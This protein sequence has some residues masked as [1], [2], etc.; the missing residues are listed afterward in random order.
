MRVRGAADWGRAASCRVLLEEETNR[1]KTE[2]NRAVLVLGRYQSRCSRNVTDALSLV[3]LWPSNG[4]SV[5]HRL[6]VM[7]TIRDIQQK[8]VVKY[9]SKKG[10]M[11][12]S[13]LLKTLRD[14][15]K[16]EPN[17]ITGNEFVKAVVHDGLNAV[18][19]EEAQFLFHFWDTMAEQQEPVGVVALGLCISD[20]LSTQPQ[21]GTGFSSGPET[22]KT[23]KGAKGN[24]PSQSGGIFGG[25]SYAADAMQEQGGALPQASSPGRAVA[26]TEPSARP[27]GNQSSI[28]GGI[29]GEAD[30]SQQ[31]PPSSRSN[32]SNQSSIQGGI[33]GEGPVAR[34]PTQQGD[35]SNRSNQSSIP[36]GIFG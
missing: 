36:G 10:N 12:E 16:T 9:E 32:R 28:P 18:T 20:L 8:I 26:R 3:A 33:F 19:V 11:T 22:L 23:N 6:R 31:P 34:M 7:T 13:K 21:Y 14:Y 15:A 17:A 2:S 4:R 35:R 30:P 5:P 27:K 29:F 1:I 24:L 25:G